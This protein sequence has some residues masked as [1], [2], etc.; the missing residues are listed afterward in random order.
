MPPTL[1]LPDY[2]GPVMSPDA[3]RIVTPASSDAKAQLFVRRLE[4]TSFVPLPGTEGARGPFWSPDSRSIAF[5][6]GGKLKR[7]G[8]DG[9]PITILCDGS[10]RPRRILES[11]WR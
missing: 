5:F 10:A 1:S 8:A 9:G 6:A 3:T 11:E 7:I 4:D 2:A